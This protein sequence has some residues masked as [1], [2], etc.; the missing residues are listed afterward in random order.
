[1]IRENHIMDKLIS[2][3]LDCDQRKTEVFILCLTLGTLRALKDGYLDP[4]AGIWS[5]GR[6]V[7]WQVLESEKL[8]SAE[9]LAILQSAD[10]L[11]A[12]K[13]LAGEAA[14]QEIIGKDISILENRLLHLK[15]T[16]WYARLETKSATAAA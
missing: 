7:F 15:E 13:T 16:S 12:L 8:V 2:L 9:V 14:F 10:E 3:H 11:A 6:P 4:D 5:L 1:V